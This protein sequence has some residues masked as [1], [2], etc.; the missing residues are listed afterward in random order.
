MH[1][2]WLPII[3]YE[4]LYEVSNLGQVRSLNHFVVQSN[5]K[6]SY[7]RLYKGK[8]LK[9][10][11]PKN[12]YPYLHLSKNGIRKTVKVHRLVAEHF[13]ANPNNFPQ[14]NHKDGDK[15]NNHKNNLEWCT[16]KHNI[17]H[18]YEN[19]LNKKSDFGVDSYGFKGTVQLLDN[20]DNVI[21]ELNGHKD[22]IEKG[23][24][25][26]GIS[27]VLTGRQKTHRGYKVR[28]INK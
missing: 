24:T 21:Y 9:P 8:I 17:N 25:S 4:E 22:I 11:I 15:T 16:S 26:C 10:R 1:E 7:L 5:S 2:E 19:N 6:G 20:E 28:R 13:L 27:S 14:V 23:F 18:A 12:K 3:N